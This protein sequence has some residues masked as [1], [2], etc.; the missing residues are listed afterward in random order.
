MLIL[1]GVY[2]FIR[3][4]DNVVFFI[5]K[6]DITSHI[7]YLSRQEVSPDTLCVDPIFSEFIN[8]VHTKDTITIH[9]SYF[10]TDYSEDEFYSFEGMSELLD[11]LL[12]LSHGEHHTQMVFFVKKLEHACC[13][14]ELIY[15]IST[16]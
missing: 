6:M 16:L 10:Y 5:F 3:K 1:H 7:D 11:G 4:I 8:I 14:Y 9:G 12:Q 2:I 13:M 15:G